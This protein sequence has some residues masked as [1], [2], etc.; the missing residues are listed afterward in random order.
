MKVSG[1]NAA[2]AHKIELQKLSHQETI[3]QQQI[4]VIKDRQI[5]LQRMKP[6]DL[7]KGSN[8]DEMS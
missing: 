6:Q 3:K 5:E 8:I 2:M 4:K 1:I 7:D